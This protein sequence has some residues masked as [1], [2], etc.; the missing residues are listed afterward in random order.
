MFDGVMAAFTNSWTRMVQVLF[1]PFNVATYMWFVVVCFLTDCGS[2]AST[3]TQTSNIDLSNFPSPQDIEPM[4]AGVG[5]AVVAV[6][7]TVG[8]LVSLVLWT[9]LLFLSSRATMVYIDGI[10]HGRPRPEAWG[11]HARAAN[12]LWT[13]RVALMVISSVWVL[14]VAGVAVT[15]LLAMGFSGTSAD[16]LVIGQLAITLAILV[17]VLPPAVLVGVVDWLAKDLAA[18]IMMVSE[19]SVMGAFRELAA[20]SGFELAGLLI[21]VVLRV[22]LSMVIAVVTVPISLMCCC[23]FVIPGVRH[24]VF[25]PVY[26]FQRSLGMQWVASLDE[27]FASLGSLEP[28]Q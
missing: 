6:I 7:A 17:T 19:T 28:V 12:S 21:Y 13:F 1:Q 2:P 22:A 5:L 16:I 9:G 3:N 24:A 4:V 18:P 26:T 10:Q 14:V 8:V 23:A 25:L 20:A 27:R 15:S 11:L